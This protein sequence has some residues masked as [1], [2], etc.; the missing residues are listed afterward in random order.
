M[1][2]AEPAAVWGPAR[3][4]FGSPPAPKTDSGSACPAGVTPAGRADDPET[5]RSP[6]GSAPTADGFR[7]Y[8]QAGNKLRPEQLFVDRAFMLRLTA[9]EMTVLAGGMRALNANHGQTAHGV[10]TDRPE[11]L[12]NEFFVNLL[13]MSTEWKASALG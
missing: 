7:N 9:P 13:D 5:C 2:A 10:F 3:C 4:G 1:T 12:T 6:C 11:T 8:L